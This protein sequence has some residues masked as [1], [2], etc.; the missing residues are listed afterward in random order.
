MPG[1]FITFCVPTPSA[2]LP[3]SWAKAAADTNSASAAMF[4][5]GDGPRGLTATIPPHCPKAAQR[6][7][8][9]KGDVEGLA[10]FL[11]LQVQHRGERLRH[12][13]LPD[14]GDEALEKAA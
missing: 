8:H 13:S 4:L 14:Q 2:M 6:N 3:P 7:R 1:M 5:I 10:L 9:A 11:A 12:L